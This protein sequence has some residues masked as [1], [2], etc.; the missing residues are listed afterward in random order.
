[1]A[2]QNLS[3]RAASMARRK[4]Q[5]NGKRSEGQANSRTRSSRDVRSSMQAGSEQAKTSTPVASSPVATVS[6]TPVKRAATQNTARSAS[7]ARRKSASSH[8]KAGIKGSDRQ[9]SK[10]MIRTRSATTAADKGDC[11]CGCEGRGDCHD[12][13]TATKPLLSPPSGKTNPGGRKRDSKVYNTNNAGRIN[14]R[15]RRQVLSK[16]GKNGADAFRKGLSSAQIV[17]HQNPQISGRDLARSVREMRSNSGARGTS[18]SL[19]TGRIRPARAAESVTGTKVSHS[20]KTTGDETGMCR[21]VTGTDYMSSE[22]FT[23]FCQTETPK[24]PVKV[25]VTN[26]SRGNAVTSGGKIGSSEK[27]TGN[28]RGSCRAVTGSEYLGNE[29][30][31]KFCKTDIQPGSA[32]VSFSKTTRGQIISGSKPARSNQ[33]TGDEPGTCKAVTGTPY[34]GMEQFEQFCNTKDAGMAS[35]RTHRSYGN[36]VGREISGIQ[37]GLKK[38]TGAEKGACESISG[39]PY[40]GAGEQTDVCGVAP[41]QMNES[42]FPQ[43]IDAPWGEFSVIAPSRASQMTEQSNAVTGSQYEQGKISGTFSLGEGKV[44]GTEQ[45]RFGDKPNSVLSDVSTQI[46]EKETGRVTGEGIATGLKITGDDWDRG[47][48]VTGT[49]GMSA[50]KRNPTRKG[51]MSAMLPVS[52]KRNEEVALAESKV[53]GGSGNTEK[54]APVTVSGGARG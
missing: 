14:S 9:R 8:G 31:N 13:A 19:P 50:T 54:G 5:V 33:V 2:S 18:T 16:Q 51:P 12:K 49:E 45:F 53:T 21:S 15:M 3:G 37:P 46:S 17:R 42:D 27:V 28:E 26:T 23:E 38:L 47:E 6:R 4:Q 35:A 43:M 10:E 41:A 25:E 36:T 20:Q 30:F 40:I 7:L 1:M 34:A 39:T 48:R 44:T 32:K 52:Q 24:V 22:V 29:H 11:G